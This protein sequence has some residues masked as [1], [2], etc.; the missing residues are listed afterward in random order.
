MSLT[1]QQ[2]QAIVVYVLLLR[3]LGVKKD[4]VYLDPSITI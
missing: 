1:E 3:R 4:T 2:A